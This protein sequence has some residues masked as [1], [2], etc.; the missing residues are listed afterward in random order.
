MTCVCAACAGDQ[1]NNVPSP[2][3]QLPKQPVQSPTRAAE[4]AVRVSRG[5]TG[6]K[7]EDEDEDEESSG[8]ESE[9]ASSDEESIIE[10][11]AEPV[12]KVRPRSTVL[13]VAEI[14]DMQQ[15]P[16]KSSARPPSP[17]DLKPAVATMPDRNSSSSSISPGGRISQS[18]TSS[19][20]VIAESDY[21]GK[22]RSL[23][24]RA[25]Q[26]EE[27][28][29]VAAVRDQNR[30]ISAGKVPQPSVPSPVINAELDYAGKSPKSPTVQPPVAITQLAY[31]GKP[32]YVSTIPQQS[33]YRELDRE[34]VL[35]TRKNIPYVDD[36]EV[37]LPPLPGSPRRL[38]TPPVR[39]SAPVA[40][41]A[42]PAMPFV[43]QP[44]VVH[45]FEPPFVMA[46]RAAAG[47]ILMQPPPASEPSA[48]IEASPVL[49][50]NPKLTDST[51]AVDEMP[52]ARVH[53][54]PVSQKLPRQT[55]PRAE[56]GPDAVSQLFTKLGENSYNAKPPGISQSSVLTQEPSYG[57]MYK[58]PA[59]QDTVYKQSEPYPVEVAQ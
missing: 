53:P 43:T 30:V 57:P 4:M 16:R 52:T 6:S 8:S 27:M 46:P 45:T 33:E 44:S 31:A 29:P 3:A 19:P 13:S 10:Y 18:S 36:E 39:I 22:F 5:S 50:Y 14:T 58:P 7:K 54:P 15:S 51:A 21:A 32:R 35:R 49:R 40:S 55:A 59:V 25:S 17:L 56:T 20:M 47:P 28:V 2:A 41:P 42:A 12:P 23:P 48:R 37:P 11:D 24:N 1:G 26:S 9:A 34:P 38:T